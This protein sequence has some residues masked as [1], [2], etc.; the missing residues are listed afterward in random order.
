MTKLNVVL[1]VLLFGLL[2]VNWAVRPDPTLPGMEFLPEMVRSA[3]YGSFAENPNFADGKTLQSPVPG[4]VARGSLPLS[5]RATPE[6]ALRAGAELSNPSRPDDRAALERGAAVFTSFCQPCHGPG[7]KGD[8]PVAL[9]GYPPPPSLLVE[10]ALAMRDGQMFH[11]LTYGQGNMPSHASQV[12]RA[13]RW[14]AILHVRS[15]Q[16]Q[17]TTKAGQQ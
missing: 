4:T 3:A 6:D 7:G 5:Y 15:L 13:D 2:G 10:K 17:S 8:G 9:R 14:N 12:S 11:A 1:L 16:R